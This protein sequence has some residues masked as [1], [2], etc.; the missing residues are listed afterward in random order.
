MLSSPS[1]FLAQSPGGAMQLID[2]LART[3]LS[4]ILILILACTAVRL[5]V[6]PKLCKT[7]P[8]LRYGS[9]K[10]FKLLNDASDSIIYAGGIVFLLIRPF[11]VQTFYIPSPSMETTLM[12]KDYII[13]N[14]YVYR[15]NEPKS[16]DI[17]VFRPPA[18]AIPPGQGMQ[19]YI[20]R[21]IGTPGQV[22]EIR[23]G[24][25]Y[26]DGKLVDEPYVKLG[27]SRHDFKLVNDNGNYIPCTWELGGSINS[28]ITARDYA[29]YADDQERQERLAKL[30]P[31]AVPPGYVLMMGDN[32]NA[33]FDGR[34]WGLV[35]RRSIIGKA[36]FIWL[37]LNR[38]GRPQ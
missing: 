11:A 19:D 33:S 20:K 6:Y 38:I 12:T 14:K 1:L 4:K 5:L 26:R 15:F 13:A 30:P 10:T 32:R 3:P 21:V 7:A 23:Q 22:I 35:E 37:P 8:H 34:F 9:F 31:V 27:I 18:R 17:A 16:G 25:L 36:E 2:T 28:S 29:V 24:H